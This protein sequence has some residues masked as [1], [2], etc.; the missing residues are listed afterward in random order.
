MVWQIG[1]EEQREIK[2][3]RPFDEGFVAFGIPTM[4]SALFQ[5]RLSNFRSRA[6]YQLFSTLERSFR[7]TLSVSALLSSFLS[8]FLSAHL[9]SFLSVFLSGKLFLPDLLYVSL[10]LKTFHF[11]T[12]FLTCLSYKV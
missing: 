7:Q 8:V 4:T 9:S 11:F 1:W 12:F 10:S 2:R 5:P 6:S 3:L